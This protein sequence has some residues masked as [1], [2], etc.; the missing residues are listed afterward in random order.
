MMLSNMAKTLDP[1]WR[2]ERPRPPEAYWADAFDALDRALK[3]QLIVCPVSRIHESES[4]VLPHFKVMRR[5]YEHLGSGA[6]FQFPAHIHHVQLAHAFRATL[7]GEPVDFRVIPRGRVLR[8]DVDAWSERIRISIDW[9]A[10]DPDPAL[11]RLERTRSGEAWERIFERWATERQS[12]EDV[13]EYERRG[14]ADAMLQLFR[15][16]LALVAD[17]HRTGRNA[18]KVLNHRL[19]VQ[20]MNGLLQLA[21]EA[22]YEDPTS[23]LDVV[24]KFLYS[25]TALRVP[26]NEISALLMAALARRAAAGQKKLPSRGMWNDITAISHFLPYCDAMFVDDECASLLGEGPLDER[27]VYPTRVFSNK[28]RQEFLEYVASCEEEAGP[29]H[30][31]LVVGTYGENWLTPYRAMLQDE[32]QRTARRQ[33]EAGRSPERG[34]PTP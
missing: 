1:V 33:A 25:E 5:L 21:E 30:R 6:T 16:H 10:A 4:V 24:V 14:Q 28:T 29:A 18:E 7:R 27:I 15:E 12:F 19:E 3:L 11:V 22:G 9:P 8:G 2:A 34:T 23:A 32:R 17:F 13:Y 20:T 26:A 31:D